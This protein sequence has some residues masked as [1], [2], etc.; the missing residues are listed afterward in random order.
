MNDNIRINLNINGHYFPTTIKREDEEMVRA[1]AKKVDKL[2]NT[3]KIRFSKGQLSNEGI[4]TLVAYQL[5][6]NNKRLEQRNDTEPYIERIE[7]MIALLEEQITE[8]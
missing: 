1:A 3:V 7:S 8:E 4:V 6:I 2:I 5:A